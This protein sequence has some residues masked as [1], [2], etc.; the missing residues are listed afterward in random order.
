MELVICTG[1]SSSIAIDNR[2][3]MIKSDGSGVTNVAE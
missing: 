3:I 1:D 2:L